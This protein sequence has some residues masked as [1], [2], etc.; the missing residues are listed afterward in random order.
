MFQ[1]TKENILNSAAGVEVVNGKLIVADLGTYDLNNIV[2][3]KIYKTAGTEGTT[4][5][6]TFT[7]AAPA[8]GVESILSFR[9]VTSKALGEFASPA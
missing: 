5:S 1:Y 6:K 8:D 9:V 3:K 7:V 2:D 4:A